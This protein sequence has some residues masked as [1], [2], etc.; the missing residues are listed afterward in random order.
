MAAGAFV[1]PREG[2]SGSGAHHSQITTGYF[3][4]GALIC[5]LKYGSSTRKELPSFFCWAI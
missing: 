3:V 4:A 2:G 1:L 5:S